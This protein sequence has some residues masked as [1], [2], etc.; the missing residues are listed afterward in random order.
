[1]M[2]NNCG[3]CIFGWFLSKAWLTTVDAT[4]IPPGSHL[5]RA[6]GQLNKVEP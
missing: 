6:V 1:M 2:T 3:L 4:W 5:S